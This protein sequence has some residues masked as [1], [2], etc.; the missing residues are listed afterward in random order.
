MKRCNIKI[1]TLG[2]KVNQYESHNLSNYFRDQGYRLVTAAMADVII[3]N[4]CA[5]T[6]QAA[7]KSRQLIRQAKRKSPDALVIIIGCLSQLP[8]T[9]AALKDEVDVFLGSE[10]KSMVAEIVDKWVEG[11]LKKEE[12]SLITDF[13]G[14][15]QFDE[16]PGYSIGDRV[17]A[18]VKVQDGCEQFC[19]FCL[20][21]YMR[22][23]ERSR[24][25]EN[26]LKEIKYLIDKG[27]QEIVL[28]GIHL[29]AYGRDFAVKSSLSGLVKLVLGS[30]SVKRLRLSSVEPN[31]VTDE[32]ISLIANNDRIAPHLHL[33]LQGG[34]DKLLKAMNRKYTTADYLALINK[35]RASIPEIALTTDLM[36]GFPGET[37][38]DFANTLSFVRQVQ[39]S[40]MHV[41]RYSPRPGT[42]AAQMP[43][44]VSGS[45]ARDR[46]DQMH[47]VA[48][49]MKNS[50]YQSMI[51]KTY[52]ILI[53]KC[54]DKLLCE[55]HAGNY[56]KVCV[57]GAKLAKNSWVKV[58]IIKSS[59]YCVLGN[60]V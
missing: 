4:T 56:V 10:H 16:M 43:L 46:S 37:E 51:G 59:T 25:P 11:K 12:A 1:L 36:V 26:V 53:E 13:S 21:P 38:S 5:V 15:T 45:I 28:T 24:K 3:I 41:F 18:E 23:P 55:G 27:Y 54:D 20:I 31:D 35:V 17:R 19:S 29:G 7:R 44:Q 42:K 22:G 32:L 14:V 8:E 48:E 39:F 58:Q 52:Q 33:P 34:N 6:M 2:C 47:A 40:N 60:V 9:R 57:Q 30:T 49:E 50:Y